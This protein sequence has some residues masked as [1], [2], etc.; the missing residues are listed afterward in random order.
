MFTAFFKGILLATKNW[1]LVLLLLVASILFSIPVVIPIFLLIVTTTASTAA[2]G[3]MMAD[4]L[5]APWAADLINQQFPGFSLESFGIQLGVGILIMG[6]G[7]LLLNIFFA[8]GI[9]EV[10]ASEDQRFSMRKFWS[11]SGAHFWRFTR[12]TLISL[13][14]YG[15]AIT[16]FLLVRSLIGRVESRAEAFESVV[17]K[18]W[19]NLFLLLLMIAFVNMIFDYARISTVLNDSRKMIRETWRAIV[20]SIKNFLGAYVLYLLIAVSG[21]GVFLA[22]STLRSLIAQNGM[23]TVF[24]AFLLA[25]IALTAR[26]WNKLNF[27]ASEMLYYQDRTRPR[28]AEL[29]F[30][31]PL[32]IASKEE[33][34]TA[35][36]AAAAVTPPAATQKDR[37]PGDEYPFQDNIEG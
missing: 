22:F 28:E 35:D 21:L 5:Y 36:A 18:T 37:E 17:Y 32:N 27:Y 1:K 12:L 6:I 25:Q 29:D 20:F 26:M 9:L 4:N 34:P 24:L 33:A 10:F 14:F 11:G 31:S 19:F 7:Y 16:I 23:G 8:G 13:V 3:Q 30:K 2:S 15:V